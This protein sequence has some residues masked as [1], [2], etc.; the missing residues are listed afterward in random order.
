MAEKRIIDVAS[1]TDTKT[2]IGSKPMIVG[3]KSMASDPMMRE[4]DTADAVLETPESTSSSTM[5][6]KAEEEKIAPPSAT[7]KTLEPVKAEVVENSKVPETE[8][9]TK[10]QG[11]TKEVEKAD[12]VT[13]ETNKSEEKTDEETAKKDEVDP[14]AIEMEKEEKLRKL[15]E[16]KK[17]FVNIKQANSGS[18]KKWF[19]AVLGTTLVLLIGLF[20]LIDTKTLDLGIDLPFRIFGKETNVQQNTTVQPIAQS[21]E[22]SVT[23]T[24]NITVSKIVNAEIPEGYVLFD[25]SKYGFTFSY[26]AEFGDVKQDEETSDGR[27]RFTFV[28]NSSYAFSINEKGRVGP[29]GHDNPTLNLQNFTNDSTN[30]IYN[31]VYI[32]DQST[33]NEETTNILFASNVD[34]N[35][36]IVAE[37]AGIGYFTVGVATINHDLYESIVVDYFSTYSKETAYTAQDEGPVQLKQILDTFRTAI[38]E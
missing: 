15:I 20:V 13:A 24:K 27:I 30:N 25:G 23:K 19:F 38:A 35:K 22:E 28:D 8:S 16:S 32:N 9:D 7:Q 3:H 11:A 4:K 5:E 1:P 21:K 33:T 36:Y 2:D 18:F 6:S 29:S 14:L 12:S 26:P 34:G 31:L 37:G 17:Y 10:P